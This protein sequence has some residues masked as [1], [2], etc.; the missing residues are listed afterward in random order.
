MFKN[1]NGHN[2]N[3]R[4]LTEAVRSSVSLGKGEEHFQLK[5]L[6]HEQILYSGILFTGR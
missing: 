4:D 1:R 3:P 6:I 2:P 5:I